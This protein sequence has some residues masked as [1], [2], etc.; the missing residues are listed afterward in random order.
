LEFVGSQKMYVYILQVMSILRQTYC[1]PK[2]LYY[3]LPG[4]EK[5]VRNPDGTRRKETLIHTVEEFEK[6][7]D[8]AV[9]SLEE[10][11]KVLRH[12]QEYGAIS[13]AYFP[14][15]SILPC[16]AAL[17]THITTL[18]ANGQLDAQRKLRHWY[19]SSVFNNRY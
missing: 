11:I 6:Q 17:R 9:D 5:I 3:L 7:W 15:E 19:W 1:S 13:S 8:Q 16:F 10:S 2:Y 14:Y 18:P 4:Q 12:P